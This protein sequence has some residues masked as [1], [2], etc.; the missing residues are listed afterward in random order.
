MSC[1]QAYA[2]FHYHM[3]RALYGRRTN[4]VLRYFRHTR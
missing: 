2:K 1:R 3:G 4:R